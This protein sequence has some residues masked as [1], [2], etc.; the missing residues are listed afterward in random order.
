MNDYLS[1]TKIREL[2]QEQYP[3]IQGAKEFRANNPLCGD[4]IVITLQIENNYITN[5]G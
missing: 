5:C 4:K 2:A 1:D 3:L